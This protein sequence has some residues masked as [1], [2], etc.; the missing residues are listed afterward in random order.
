[1]K[2][3]VIDKGEKYLWK[4]EQLDPEPVERLAKTTNL[5]FAIARA[6]WQRGIRTSGE[7]EQFFNPSLEQLPPPEALPDLEVAAERVARA[8]KTGEPLLIFGDYDVDGL[9]A[10]AMLI[11]AFKALGGKVAGTIP[12]RSDEGYGLNEKCLRQAAAEGYKLVVTVDCG[13]TAHAEAE[14]AREL[15][16][17]LIITDH[18]EPGESLPEALAVVDCKR[19]DADYPFPH[20]AGV[21]V[22]F[23]LLVK[24]A[25]YFGLSQAEVCKGF[26]DLVALGTIADVVPLTGENRVLA[27]LG[28]RALQRTKKPGLLALLKH[29]HLME[30]DS[31]QPRQLTAWHVAFVLAPRLNSAGRVAKARL[32]LQLLLT[33]KADRAEELAAQL[34]DLNDE[35]RRQQAEILKLADAEARRQVE[36]EGQHIIIV[37]DC[38]VMDGQKWN[39][40]IIGIV[41]SQLVQR[42]HRPALVLAGFDGEFQGEFRG[43][44]RSTEE[45]NLVEALQQC[46]DLL[47]KAGGHARAA[48]LTLKPE[49]LAEFKRRLNHLAWE[50]LTSSDVEPSL[51]VD[52][53]LP[54]EELFNGCFKCDL[55]RLAP[56]GEG[57]P[58][59]VWVSR[60]L[61]VLDAY[62]VGKDKSH[63]KLVLNAGQRGCLNAIAFGFGSAARKVYSGVVLDIAYT[64][65][66]NTY[67]NQCELEVRIEDFAIQPKSGSR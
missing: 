13:I 40:G 3:V 24:V 38:Q 57:N 52:A 4:L 62:A 15:G 59:P 50:Q 16:L 17:D 54:L 49:N 30:K 64:L 25:S 8:I 21:G 19:Q 26:L 31:S 7:V 60:G 35:R 51:K 61:E 48:G 20:L 32:A 2:S 14:L 22:A 36:V 27:A 37:D 10:T 6:L 28:L 58:E 29:S 63:L 5:P 39:P 47:E 56:F 42:Y 44:G 66:D 34:C 43:S 23:K 11:R 65:G 18:H 53:E 55:D 45:F 9:T 67:P 33:G 1:M 46:E 12:E 41:A